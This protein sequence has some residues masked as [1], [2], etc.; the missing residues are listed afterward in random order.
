[1]M[2]RYYTK[3]R[4]ALCRAGRG[5]FSG[6][7]ADLVIAFFTGEADGSAGDDG[8]DEEVVGGFADD[9]DDAGECG[10]EGGEVLD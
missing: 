7:D 8:L 1:M 3:S 6:F 9:A 5:A 2:S 4:P 10:G